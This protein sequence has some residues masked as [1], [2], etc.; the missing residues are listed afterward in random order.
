[1]CFVSQIKQLFGFESINK[2]GKE[3]SDS[4]NHVKKEKPGLLGCDEI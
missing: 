1:M 2:K 4:E 3:K